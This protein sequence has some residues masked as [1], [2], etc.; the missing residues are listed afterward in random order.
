MA[1]ISTYLR[2]KLLDHANGVAAYTPPATIYAALCGPSATAAQLDAGSIVDEVAGTGYARQALALG[3]ATGG[4]AENSAAAS[5][6]AEASDWP[7]VR[8]VVLMDAA[9]GGNV[10]YFDQLGTDRQMVTATTLSV[11]I[12]DYDISITA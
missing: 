1:G 6:T 10:M 4:A 11:P 7:D 2:N 3:A 9:T 5:F 8:F 12:G